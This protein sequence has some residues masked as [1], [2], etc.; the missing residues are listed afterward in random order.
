MVITMVVAGVL[1][2]MMLLMAWNGY[3]NIELSRL[4]GECEEAAVAPVLQM[5]QE[6]EVHTK[7]CVLCHAPLSAVATR[8][9]V[10]LELQRKIDL[11]QAWVVNF[12]DRPA[13]EVFARNLYQG[14]PVNSG[15]IVH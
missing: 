2:G 14:M 6:E 9:E 13:P 15:N 11:E 5:V 3:R 12:I 1:F 10:V 4:D 8:D 7:R